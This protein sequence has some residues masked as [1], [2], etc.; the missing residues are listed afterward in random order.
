MIIKLL[1]LLKKWALPIVIFYTITLTIASLIN[2]GR[3]PDLGSNFDDKIYH[4]IAYFILTILLFNYLNKQQISHVL[5][6]T[7][8]IVIIYG[9]IIEVLQYILTSYRTLD[10]YDAMANTFGVILAIIAIKFSNKL[11]LK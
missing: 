4:V 9:I 1:L 7:G 2:I 10:F 3:V 8:V 11:K 6:K 5:L